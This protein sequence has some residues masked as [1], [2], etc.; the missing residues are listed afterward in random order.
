[1]YIYDYKGNRTE[2]PFELED[3]NIKHVELLVLSGDE[4]LR[5]TYY[6]PAYEGGPNELLYAEYDSST[7]R[8]RS[9]YE[10]MVVLKT[11]NHEGGLVQSES[12][13]KGFKN[14][15]RAFLYNYEGW[16]RGEEEQ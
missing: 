11:W 3:E 1:M 14:R 15:N 10:A 6:D 9:I 13:Y 7:T 8:Q 4:F 2:V 5:V 16:E 12:F